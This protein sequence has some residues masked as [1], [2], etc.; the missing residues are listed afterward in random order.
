MFDWNAVASQVSTLRC[1]IGTAD[2]AAQL[3]KAHELGVSVDHLGG[4]IE[5]AGNSAAAV[6]E[7]LSNLREL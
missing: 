1:T 6:K 5:K 3:S 4:V 2:S 7:E